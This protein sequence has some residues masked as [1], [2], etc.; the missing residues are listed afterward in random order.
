MKENLKKDSIQAEGDLLK[1][2]RHCIAV[3]R[4]QKNKKNQTKLNMLMISMTLC[5]YITWTPYAMNCLL[6][7]AGIL[8]PRVANVIAILFAKFGTVV[9]PL[10]YIFFNKDVS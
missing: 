6:A 3:K 5:F 4:A 2:N 1:L 8:L 9:N 7:M 10:L